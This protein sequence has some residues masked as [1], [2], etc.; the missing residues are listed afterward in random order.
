MQKI[1][2]KNQSK[3]YTY[4]SVYSCGD[5][6]KQTGT[7]SDK[8]QEHSLRSINTWQGNMMIGKEQEI[9][10]ITSRSQQKERNLEK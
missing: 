2:S 6:I 4:R 7:I 5:W 3:L 10:L 9:A 1:Q 8:T